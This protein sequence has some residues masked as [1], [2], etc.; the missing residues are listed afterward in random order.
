GWFYTSRT[1]SATG[2]VEDIE[3][4]SSKRDQKIIEKIRKVREKFFSKYL[5]KIG[6]EII[7]PPDQYWPD[8]GFVDIQ[9]CKI[10]GVRSVV[11][12]GLSNPDLP[13]GI[14]VNIM[15]DEHVSE[16]ENTKTVTQGFELARDL[17][18]YVP[19]HLAGYGYELLI[20]LT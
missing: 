3:R 7:N 18:R 11:T 13:T 1:E 9:K 19:Y 14:R 16:D 12:V 5:G 15:G 17:P 8:G 2:E 20:L 6:G 4:N 10:R